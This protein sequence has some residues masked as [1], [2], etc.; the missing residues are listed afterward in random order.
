M[1]ISIESDYVFT[2]GWY[3]NGSFLFNNNGTD[4]AIVNPLQLDFNFS[5]AH[6]M[7]TKWNF[8][9]AGGK[10]FTPLFSA[11]LSV[12]YAPGTHLLLILPGL[13]Y[14]LTD[15]LNADLIWQSFFANLDRFEALNHRGYLRLKYNF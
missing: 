6:L 9:L 1:N 14:S 13:R 8:I 7:P 2:S 15:N 4:T 5:P 10:E 3:L 11:N 12:L